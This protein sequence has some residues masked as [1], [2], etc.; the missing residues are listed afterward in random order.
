MNM[1]TWRQHLINQSLAAIHDLA[2][3]IQYATEHGENEYTNL[4]FA[5]ELEKVAEDQL[6]GWKE[7][8]KE[9]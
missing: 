5:E 4:R 3:L 7:N 2:N 1:A 8:F 6:M 9:K